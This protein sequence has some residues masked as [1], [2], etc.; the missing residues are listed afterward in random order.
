MALTHLGPQMLFPTKINLQPPQLH[1]EE[2]E[3][4]H[5]SDQ[6]NGL[7]QSQINTAAL[8][9]YQNPSTPLTE[10]TINSS[11]SQ[12]SSSSCIS[13]FGKS[14]PRISV[15]ERLFGMTSPTIGNCDNILRNKENEE[16]FNAFSTSETK[17]NFTGIDIPTNGPR[18]GV[19]PDFQ[20][21][22]LKWFNNHLNKYQKNA[23]L[24]ILNGEARPLP[25]VIFGPP[26]TGKTVTVVEAIL[27]ILILLP[28]SR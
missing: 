24:N 14:P 27:Q 13:D 1:I 28:D 9:I 19:I 26:G 25:Y 11:L 20:K 2:Q 10:N 23:V 15:V 18:N 6:Y 5:V 22:K 16:N 8:D 7:S 17:I 3:Y 4:S 21:R 12:N